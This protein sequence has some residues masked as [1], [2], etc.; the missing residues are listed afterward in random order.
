LTICNY[1]KL[2]CAA[3][4]TIFYL[5]I[6]YFFSVFFLVPNIRYQPNIRQHFLAEYSFSAETEKSVFGRK[7]NRLIVFTIKGPSTRAILRTILRTNRRTILCTISCE[8]G[9]KFIFD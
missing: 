9:W 2:A 1:P 6:P 7:Y 3:K 4:K 8:G 5:F